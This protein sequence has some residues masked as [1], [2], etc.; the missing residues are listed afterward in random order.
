MSYPI[1]RPRFAYPFGVPEFR[2]KNDYP[3]DY[4]PPNGFVSVLVA[5]E[6]EIEIPIANQQVV[7]DDYPSDDYSF[8]VWTE[9]GKTGTQLTERTDGGTLLP[10]EFALD[11]ETGTVAFAE[12]D[13]THTVFANYYRIMSI[14]QGTE[15][16]YLDANVKFIADGLLNGFLHGLKFRL[17]WGAASSVKLIDITG[18]SGV[19]S[20][21]DFVLYGG[22]AGGVL[23][24]PFGMRGDGQLFGL[25]LMPALEGVGNIGST[26]DPANVW[27]GVGANLIVAR[28]KIESPLIEAVEIQGPA[29]LAVNID[30][31]LVMT[32]GSF[33]LDGDDASFVEITED[34]ETTINA[35]DDGGSDA[36][37]ALNI[38]EL[39]VTRQ[40]VITTGEDP[41]HTETHLILAPMRGDFDFGPGGD[42]S[43]STN[44]VGYA[45][46]DGA[47][48]QLYGARI[49][50]FRIFVEFETTVGADYISQVRLISRDPDS[51]TILQLFTSGALTWGQ[52]DTDFHRE[53]LDI[54]PAI[55]LHR[56]GRLFGVEITCSNTTA[57]SIR[58]GSAFVVCRFAF[59]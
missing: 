26:S 1:G 20:T 24:H 50:P 54:S 34:G 51:I 44:A 12:E 6:V 55:G 5:V 47:F 45:L 36:R 8:E 28:T 52:G 29:G 2:P 58:V 43:N 18:M 49:K 14:V 35:Y 41:A 11:W 10:D 37:I 57:N 56:P 4:D 25:G 19:P 33:L 15:A 32:D 9:T 59:A 46:S 3:R 38:G 40:G 42:V 22:D 48:L 16:T 53:F 27:G 23:D 30:Q 7:L 31:G 21:E 39:H 13:A 17:D